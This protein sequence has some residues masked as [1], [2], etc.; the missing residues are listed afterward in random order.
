MLKIDSIT[1][2]LSV[3][4]AEAHNAEPVVPRSGSQSRAQRHKPDFTGVSFD[5]SGLL[6]RYRLM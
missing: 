2:H 4:R 5:L 6:R 3:T 1:S